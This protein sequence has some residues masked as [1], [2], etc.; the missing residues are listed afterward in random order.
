MNIPDALESVTEALKS[1]GIDARVDPRD[2]NTP[3]AW[4]AAR[5]WTPTYMCGDGETTIDVY[6]IVDDTGIVQAYSGLNDLLSKALTVL[7]VEG[8]VSLEDSVTLP[9]GGG[10]VP[11]FRLTT[12]VS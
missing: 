7:D 12:V 10:P 11:A 8:D 6:L 3:C 5:K 9:S 1:A 4:V 2:L